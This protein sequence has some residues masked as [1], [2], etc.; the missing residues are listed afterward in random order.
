MYLLIHALSANLPLSTIIYLSPVLSMGFT[1][2]THQYCVQ[3]VL[4]QP[5]R[6]MAVVHK[7]VFRP[8]ATCLKYCLKFYL[9]QTSTKNR[10]RISS[11]K[12]CNLYFAVDVDLSRLSVKG[13]LL[14]NWLWLTKH[15]PGLKHQIRK[16]SHCQVIL[17]I[18]FFWETF[19]KAADCFPWWRWQ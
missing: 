14:F 5:S 2:A 4:Y 7:P 1:P 16:V 17:R 18:L 10:S 12:L 9:K 6:L 11:L 13:I 8:T 3:V 19:P 15:I